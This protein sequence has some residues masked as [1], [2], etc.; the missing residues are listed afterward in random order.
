MT[1]EGAKGERRRRS[2][3][4]TWTRRE[5]KQRRN[6]HCVV[7][8]GRT[9]GGLAPEGSARCTGGKA[10]EAQGREEEGSGGTHYRRGGARGDD[11]RRGGEKDAKPTPSWL[12]HAVVLV[13][14]YS[15][16]HPL[17][18]HP[19]RHFHHQKNTNPATS[20]VTAFAPMNS[21]ANRDS[22]RQYCRAPPHPRTAPLDS[23]IPT[24]IGT[25]RARVVSPHQRPEQR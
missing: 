6:A 21:R 8:R 19:H 5:L 15:H 25:A 17:H 9:R 11:R 20:S 12:K 10:E 3:P 7:T 13:R 23:R 16:H 14:L 24:R 2:S 22:C 18:H 1:G 4:K